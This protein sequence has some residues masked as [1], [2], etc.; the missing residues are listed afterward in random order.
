[1]RRTETIKTTAT[2]KK[3]EKLREKK[4]MNTNNEKRNR[5]ACHFARIKIANKLRGNNLLSKYR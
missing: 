1:M 3:K 4:Q 2:E 5:N